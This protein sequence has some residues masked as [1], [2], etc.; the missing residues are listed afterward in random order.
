MSV[1]KSSEEIFGGWRG[2]GRRLGLTTKKLAGP[3]S[4][5]Q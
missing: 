4:D 2:R 5:V 3:G 1:K